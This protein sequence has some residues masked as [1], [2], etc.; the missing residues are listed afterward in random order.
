MVP[1]K[2]WC[3][4][5]SSGDGGLSLLPVSVLAMLALVMTDSALVEEG[6]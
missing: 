4:L 6:L 1:P 2:R 5:G 3:F